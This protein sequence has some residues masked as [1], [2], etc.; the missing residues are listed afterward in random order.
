MFIKIIRLTLTNMALTNKTLLSKYSPLPKNYNFDEIMLYQ[1]ISIA[2]WV[3][4]IL[5]DAFT[6]ALE[7]EVEH[8]QVS[9][10][11]S[12]LMTSGGLLQ[13]LSYAM[14]YEGL[15]FIFAHFSE[16]GITLPD[17]DNSKSVDLKELNY[18][19][20][21]L[22]RTLEFLKDNLI[23]WLDS[24]SDSFPLYHPIN[25]GSCCEKKG[26]NLPNSGWQIY[27]TLKHCTDLI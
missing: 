26:L 13:Y 21:H 11:N 15:P 12:T 22:R 5:G 9:E 10:E 6:E 17:V 4:P 8:N 3:R 1:P 16:V 20:D 24:H 25:C 19:Q 2:I 23:K 18:I 7:Y 14:C 27:T